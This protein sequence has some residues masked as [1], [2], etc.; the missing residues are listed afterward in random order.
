VTSEEESK[1]NSKDMSRD[2][3]QLDSEEQKK[4]DKKALTY[5]EGDL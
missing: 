2:T 1:S 5:E 3:I 4:G